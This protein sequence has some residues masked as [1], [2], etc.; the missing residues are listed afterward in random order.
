MPGHKQR[1]PSALAESMLGANIWRNDVSEMGGFDYLHAPTGSIIEAQSAAA[2]T[3][4]AGRTFFLVGGSTVG[5]LAAFVAHAGDGSDV[6]VFRGSHRS[7]YAGI[8]LSGARPHYLPIVHDHSEDGWFLA[9]LA[10]LAQLPAQLAIVHVT[11]P[12]Y[13]GMACDLAPYREFADRTGALLV[14]DEAHGSHFGFHPAFP[15]SALREGADVV[16]QST[17]KTLRA[18]TQASMLHVREGYN[19]A[20]IERVLP[21]LQSSSPSAL[22]TVSLDLARAELDESADVLFGDLFMRCEDIRHDI[23]GLDGFRVVDHEA[24]GVRQDPAKIVIDVS[25]RGW[26]GF[27]A[28]KWLREH[29]RV[30]IEL[31]DF[32]R[33]VCSLTFGDDESTV[34]VLLDALHRLHSAEPQDINALGSLGKL[35]TPPQV[36]GPRAALNAP[37]QAI[38]IAIAAN[39]TCAEYVIPYPPGIPLVVPGEQLTADVLHTLRA[40]RAAGANIVGPADQ[41]GTTINVVLN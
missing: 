33:I 20:R 11:R 16:I 5:N 2:V 26:T 32:R 14:V 17:H 35:P 23:A 34:R 1:T 12:N 25:G 4:G 38:P 9:D 6:A 21:M 40:F 24:E 19:A 41:S 31:A 8:V 30:W 39:R 13:Y 18:L 7:V 37:V 22:L 27:A 3:F 29:E 10:A 28:S 15:A 36:L